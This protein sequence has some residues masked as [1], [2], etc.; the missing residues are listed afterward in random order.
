MYLGGTSIGMVEVVMVLQQ[1]TFVACWWK[2]RMGLAGVSQIMHECAA[3]GLGLWLCVAIFLR[4][5]FSNNV[6]DAAL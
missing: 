1:A 4:V 6:R 3:G 5:I 2:T